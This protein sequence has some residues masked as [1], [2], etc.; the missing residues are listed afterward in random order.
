MTIEK[1]EEIKIMLNSDFTVLE[2]YTVKDPE[3]KT[4]VESVEFLHPTL[5]KM[6]AE[7]QRRPKVL[8]TKTTYSN[9]IGSSVKVDH[10]YS[11]SEEVCEFKLFTWQ[12]GSDVWQQSRSDDFG[13]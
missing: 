11:D 3:N 4:V 13:F 9:R 5:G 1:W 2:N 10:I 7:F 6:K 12:A 8:Q